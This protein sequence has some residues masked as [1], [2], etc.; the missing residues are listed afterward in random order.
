VIALEAMLEPF[1]PVAT[2][3]GQYHAEVCR[4]N[5]CT[6]CESLLIKEVPDA[7]H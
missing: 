1:C 4:L 5:G 3:G 2:E 6:I 7:T